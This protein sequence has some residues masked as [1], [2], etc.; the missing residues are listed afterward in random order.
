MLSVRLRAVNLGAAQAARAARAA[1]AALAAR[2]RPGGECPSHV[3]AGSGAENGAAVPSMVPR[4]PD[5]VRSA[6]RAG[7]HR[8]VRERCRGTARDAEGGAEPNRHYPWPRP[9]RT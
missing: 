9:G 5:L 3:S 4:F 6:G 1:L 7:F 2:A 8:V